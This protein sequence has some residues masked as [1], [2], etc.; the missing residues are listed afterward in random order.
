MKNTEYKDVFDF[1]EEALSMENKFQSFTFPTFKNAFTIGENIRGM[2]NV[3]PLAT[4]KLY[5]QSSDDILT[6]YYPDSNPPVE[7]TFTYISD[8]RSDLAKYIK[9]VQDFYYYGI[10]DIEHFA[11]KVILFSST[12]A[13]KLKECFEVCK[14]KGNEILIFVEDNSS[15]SVS[16]TYGAIRISQNVLDT[17]STKNSLAY[18]LQDNDNVYKQIKKFVPSLTD[19]Q[20]NS[21]F[22][23]GYIEDP[24]IKT[25]KTFFQIA[26]F[27]TSVISSIFPSLGVFVNPAAR[28]LTSSILKEVIEEIEDLRFEENRWQPKPPKLDNGDSDPNYRYNPILSIGSD[29]G[30]INF[31]EIV[32]Y[33]QDKLKEQH[34]FVRSK[35]KIKKEFSRYAEPT[36]LLEFLYKKYVD[37]YYIAWDTINKLNEIS[38]LEV[39]KYGVRAY[40]A[41]LC[42]VWNGLIDAISGLFAMVKMIY[43]GLSLGADFAQNV[44]KYLPV[45]LEQF[46][47]AIQAIQN[48]DFTEI[49][50]Y[51]YEKIKEINLTFDPV[52]CSY[53]LGYAYGFI[54]SLIIEIILTVFLTGGTVTVPL[55]IEKLE[56]V[57][58]GIFRLGFG[59]AKGALKAVRTFA[60]FFLKSI[61]DLIKGFQELLNFLKKGWAE[62]KRMLDDVFKRSIKLMDE[63]ASIFIKKLP[64]NIGKFVDLLSKNFP[65]LQKKIIDGLLVIEFKGNILAKINPKGI[66]VEIKY[67]RELGNYTYFA[68]L[69]K[70]KIELEIVDDSGRKIIKNYE[71]TV[72][73]MKKGDDVS[74]RAKFEE[75]KVR[76]GEYINY[77]YEKSNSNPPYATDPKSKSR[78]IDKFLKEGDEFYIVESKTQNTPGGFLTDK[79]IYTI[80]DLREKLA[81]LESWKYPQPGDPLV[82]RKYKVLKEFQ[83]RDGWIG[84]MKETTK[85]SANFG[86]VYKGGNQQYESLRRFIREDVFIPSEDTSNTGKAIERIESFTKTLK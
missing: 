51:V 7:G 84:P 49:A 42:G 34:N 4:A 85:G 26:S 12:E 73:V 35:L 70:I 75:G 86:K 40:N 77:T 53:F 33:L 28:Q 38:N 2:N 11:F 13:T 39:L 50:K 36:S 17:L 43:D 47:E 10:V 24:R 67:F 64:S 6:K 20:I 5:N 16:G 30:I 78:V 1:S 80:K 71:D 66:I 65:K 52:A 9:D 46:D 25:A 3:S 74:F 79:P 45:L 15:D 41:L 18:D 37:A 62:I 60:N 76:D 69:K 21:L 22:H 8:I 32:N 48:I 72:E 63:Q 81:V 82:I 68:E 57:I 83:V 27:F 19:E 54:L 31:S 44:E 29:N 58:F 14:P 23:K 56:E 61:K 55:M 59:I